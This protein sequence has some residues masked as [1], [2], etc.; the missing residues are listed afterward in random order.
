MSATPDPKTAS[1]RTDALRQRAEERLRL[2]DNDVPRMSSTEVR[3]L[4]HE[5]QVTQIELHMQNEELQRAQAEL[6][7]ARDR[8]SDL[9][10]FAPVGYLTL[11]PAGVI[12]EA[13][14]TA[15][16]LLGTERARL[17]GSLLSRFLEMDARDTLYLHLRRGM[18]KKGVRRCDLAV[19]DTTGTPR[20]LQMEST[21]V[22]DASG[23]TT[24]YH[25]AISDI[26]ARKEAEQVQRQLTHQ[27]LAV[28]EHE[29]RHLARE[30]HDEVMQTLTALQMNL[31][32]VAHDAP[33][34][35]EPLRTSMALVDDLVDQI[36]T[37]SLE[38]RPTML[39][40]LG[41][42]AALEW[43]CR[44]Q[45]PRLGLRAHYTHAFAPPRPSSVV[46]TA[47]FRVVQEAITNVAKHAHTDEVWVDLQREDTTLHLIV[48]DH[49]KGFAVE[50]TCQRA[51]QQVGIGLRGMEERM[52]L[53]GGRLDIRSTPGHGTEIHV[54]VPLTPMGEVRHASD[55]GTTR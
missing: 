46:E 15:A 22:R 33:M 10:D 9:Y 12:V 29:R 2:T 6:T 54:W 36:R 25:A 11:T 44:Q 24:Q 20:W 31:D 3:R 47:C 30:L 40:E 16:S 28:Q 14:L 5:L 4:V 23:I 8:Y 17:I 21:V 39:D 52:R 26:T 13:N 49:G 42:S 48:R 53:V 43:Y 19:R 27:L 18:V 1:A 34:V 38:L 35:P 50:A 37:L 45:V 51:G 7:A 41:L 55:P 32:R